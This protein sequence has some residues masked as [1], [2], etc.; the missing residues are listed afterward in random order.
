MSRRG[1]AA[2]SIWLICGVAAAIMVMH[3]RYTADL[4]A[5]L[6]RAPTPTQQ[7][8]VDQLRDGLASRLILIGIES[9]DGAQRDAAALALAHRLRASQLF[10]VVNN[11]E[12]VNADRDR[13]LLFSHRYLLSESVTPERFTVDGLRAAIQNSL[14]LLSSPAGMLL[15]ELL[16][17]DPTGEMLQI[18]DQLGARSEPPRENGIWVSRDG[19][20]SL[21]VAETRAAGSDTDGQEQA[22]HAVREAFRASTAGTRTTPALLLSGPGVFAVQARATIRHEIVKLSLLSTAFI[23]L[24]LIAVYRSLPALLLGFVPVVSGALAGVAAVS[25]GFGAVH[26]ITLGFGVTLIGESVDYSIYLFVQSRRAANL[27]ATLW[28][29]ILLGVLTSIAGFASLLPSAFPGLAQLGLYSISGLIAAAL[30]TRFVLPELLP[31]RLRIRDLSRLGTRIGSL[32]QALQARRAWLLAVPL[33]AAAVLYAHR[34]SLWNWELSGLSPVSAQDE[35][36][37]TLLRTDLGAPDARYI[38]AVSG[39][40]Q[41]TVLRSSE[42]IS[43]TLSDLL[44][45][46]VIAG[47]ESPSNFLPSRATQQMRRASLPSPDELRDHL[48]VALSG[49][50]LRAE[51]LEPFIQDVAAARHQADLRRADLMGTSLAAGSDAL[52]LHA[53]TRWSALL[54]L[55][56]AGAVDIDVI[57]VHAALAK[58]GASDA[59]VLDVKREADTL[60]ATYLSEVLRLSAGGL[61][62]IVLL[63][64][65]T[66]RS[67]L[68]VLRVVAPLLLAVAAVA[69]ALALVGQR[70]TILHI[71]GMLLIVAVGSNY[72]L[73]FDRGS[74]SGANTLV[75]LTLASLVVANAATVVGFG[76]LAFSAVPVLSALGTT[77]APGAMLALL[78]SGLLSQPLPAPTPV[79]AAL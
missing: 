51:R 62:A 65:L 23:S 46:N 69:A 60:Y 75:P 43:R 55:R 7:M 56:A 2:I 58:T 73:F 40:D 19:R 4:S 74:H 21:L 52:L 29:T 36:L 42:R 5:F 54:P 67:P 66:L 63:L 34:H 1:A 37:D 59:V 15:K 57:R 79:T 41:E 39:P 8:L 16:S 72:A 13:E 71:V 32:L 12:P 26:G 45:Q 64:L 68:R 24:L 31:E 48:R 50:P 33:L 44:E 49:L 70:M 78:F 18:L 11:G 14:Q 9:T 35:A 3:A 20:R 61:I 17:R 28:P 25:L 27:R 10:V 30:V 6:P 76:V 77:V 22:V 38:V 53:G 47:F